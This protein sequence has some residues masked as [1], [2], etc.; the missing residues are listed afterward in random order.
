MVSGP[1]SGSSTTMRERPVL[2]ASASKA[3]CRVRRMSVVS[4]TTSARRSASAAPAARR[5]ARPSGAWGTASRRG[6]STVILIFGK[7]RRPVWAGIE[8][9][10]DRALRPL[11]A[12]RRHRRAG[13]LDHQRQ[14]LVVPH[15]DGGQR[16]A[17]FRE[18]RQ[19]PS[20][21]RRGDQRPR[22]QRLRRVHRADAGEVQER[23]HQQAPRGGARSTARTGGSSMMAVSAAASRNET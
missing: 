3:S 5:R 6:G 17:P 7:R 12:H 18:D 22:G 9:R 19:R 1:A 23:R 16:H 8:P 20:R 13:L 11:D 15:H 4:N 21:A 10:E 2:R 14:R